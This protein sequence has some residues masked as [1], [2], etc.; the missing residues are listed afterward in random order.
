MTYQQVLPLGYSK[1]LKSYV[2]FLKSRPHVY[3]RKDKKN[4]YI[5]RHHKCPRALGGCDNDWNIIWLTAQDH[6]M[7]HRLLWIAYRGTVYIKPMACAFHAM[8]HSSKYPSIDA[9]EYAILKQDRQKAISIAM[10]DRKCIHKD[11]IIK[12]VSIKD[13]PKYISQ[14]WIDGSGLGGKLNPA[15]RKP[16]SMLDK[17]HSKETIKKITDKAINRIRS[18]T[19]IISQKETVN[20]RNATGNNPCSRKG[21]HQSLASRQKTRSTF[22]KK[23]HQ[24]WIDEINSS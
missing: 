3:T 7:A 22:A 19:S 20:D 6:W 15:Y 21:S 9:E 23:R 18:E 16:G 12:R 14:G 11:G 10:K 17:H 1:K 13:Y 4:I 8:S 5:E 24:E 2:D